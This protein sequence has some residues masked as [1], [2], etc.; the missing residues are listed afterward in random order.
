MT[1]ELKQY[2][3]NRANEREAQLQKQEIKARDSFRFNEA[4]ECIKK[5]CNLSDLRSVIGNLKTQS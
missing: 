2:L 5:K 4:L 1:Q 3:Y